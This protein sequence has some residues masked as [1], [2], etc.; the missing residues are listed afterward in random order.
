MAQRNN[1]T[2]LVYQPKGLEYWMQKGILQA[3]LIEKATSAIDSLDVDTTGLNPNDYKIAEQFENS[4]TESRN[5]FANKLVNVG[6]L[7]VSE[8]KLLNQHIKSK[9]D[10]DE[11]LTFAKEE[12]KKA[13]KY[14]QQMS[15]WG[16]TSGKKDYANRIIDVTKNSWD[17]ALTPEGMTKPFTPP[18]VAEYV[19]VDKF[20]TD[21]YKTAKDKLSPE[22]RVTFENLEFDYVP[23]TDS[24][25]KPII[26]N[27]G[28]PVK[29]VTYKKPYGTKSNYK[30]IDEAIGV[31]NNQLSD[32][33]SKIKRYET[34]MGEDYTDMFTSMHNKGLQEAELYKREVT[35]QTDSLGLQ[36]LETNRTANKPPNT[37]IPNDYKIIKNPYVKNNMDP[38]RNDDFLTGTSWMKTF[39]D[40][41]A[42]AHTVSAKLEGGDTEGAIK[43]Y[44]ELTK[45]IKDGEVPPTQILESSS[46]FFSDLANQNDLNVDQYNGEMIAESLVSPDKGIFK[47]NKEFAQFLKS[48]PGRFKSIVDSFSNLGKW[49]FGDMTNKAIDK[50]KYNNYID[51]MNDLN[52]EYNNYLKTD[53]GTNEYLVAPNFQV[54]DKDG[55]T[56]KNYWETDIK[57]QVLQNFET[58]GILEYTR[59]PATNEIGRGFSTLGDKGTNNLTFVDKDGNQMNAGQT[60]SYIKNYIEKS[61]ISPLMIP[62]ADVGEVFPQ[63]KFKDNLNETNKKFS[64]GFVVSVPDG[65]GNLHRVI[66]ENREF[67][68][69]ADWDRPTY[70]FENNKYQPKS[71]SQAIIDTP[72]GSVAKLDYL[73]GNEGKN[74][75]RVEVFRYSDGYKYRV[76]P[77]TNASTTTEPKKK[78]EKSEKFRSLAKLHEEIN[79]SLDKVNAHI[80]SSNTN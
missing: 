41:M 15:T 25:G 3:G 29:Y 61:S 1:P 18:E 37:G 23:A 17:G 27:Y 11:K 53:A 77:A 62:Y 6:D 65:K 24:S 30:A 38:V 48:K 32:P 45:K 36:K 21:L 79:M 31:I 16:I 44:Q 60:Q 40:N 33:N 50:D 69:L 10:L 59:D 66:I 5:N 43:S 42:D 78:V 2:A 73:V 75:V 72:V 55:I 57:P 4:I 58:L 54:L 76:V 46:S 71:T 51:A 47:G 35:D 49:K 12:E 8:I 34:F 74:K 56:K 7:N 52:A 22:D 67:K 19:D 13:Q 26:D 20:Y 63:M 9:Q 39:W 80:N 70:Q 28:N 68:K 64:N 14:M